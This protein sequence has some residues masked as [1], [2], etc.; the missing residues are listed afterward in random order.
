MRFGS[1]FSGWLQS[2][3]LRFGPTSMD[4]RRVDRC[5]RSSPA[6]NKKN[7]S[8]EGFFVFSF[9]SRVFFVKWGCNLI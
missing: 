3:F 9:C 4:L 2:S 7:I 1:S 5:C 8:L 6:L